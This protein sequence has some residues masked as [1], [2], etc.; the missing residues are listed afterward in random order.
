MS[1][2]L[3]LQSNF[4]HVMI[5]ENPELQQKARS[6]IPHQ[7]LCSAAEQKLTEAKEVDPGE[8]P[9]VSQDN[10][11]YVEPYANKDMH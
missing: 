2:F 4:Q 5:Y 10:R 1:F 3:S 7:Q 11:L 8:V 9:V 6:H